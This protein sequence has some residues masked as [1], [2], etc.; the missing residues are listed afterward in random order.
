MIGTSDPV[1]ATTVRYEPDGNPPG[2][3]A[4][5]CGLQLVIVGVT[6]LVLIPALVFRAAGATETYLS[7]AVFCTVVISGASTA[8]Q[9]I[10]IGRLGAGY[11]LC[12]GPA[13]AVIGISVTA[14]VEGGPA[15]LAGLVVVS[16]LLPILVAARLSLFRRLVT[17][18]LVGTVKMLIAA[19]VLPVV[20]GRLNE[21]PDGT[22]GPGAPL[23]AAATMLVISVISLKGAA[24]LRPWA[25][26]MGVVAGSAVAA[27]FG[28]YDPDRVAAAP[29][30]GL[31]PVAWPGIESELG[32]AFVGLLPAFLFVALIGAVQTVTAAVG[33]QRVSWRR[34]RAVDSRSVQGA[35]AADG[36][37]GLLA[38][39]AGT[40]PTQTSAVSIPAAALTGVG[41]RR[42]GIAAGAVMLG[43]AFL[44]K[45][46]ALLLAIP[47]PVAVAFI[48]VLLAL[49]LVRGMSQ[50]VHGGID[51][52]NVLIAGVA[53][54]VGV[55]C[56]AGVI[57]PEQLPTL[58]G[59]LLQNGITVG[60]LV[61]I[62]MTLV[63]EATA[64]RP[65]RLAVELDAAGLSKLRA[66]VAEFASRG[67]WDEKMA[68]RLEAASDESLRALLD[69]DDGRAEREGRRV[70]LS[71]RKDVRGAILEFVAAPGEDNMGDWIGLAAE[72]PDDVLVQQKVSLRLLRRSASSVLH[73]QFHETDIVTVRVD[74][75]GTIAG[76]L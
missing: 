37:A 14:L 28:H 3:L 20:F 35:V 44:P 6:G 72:R 5:G 65:G 32:P 50:V 67:G 42:V 29:W 73:Q 45:A 40:M 60:G 76:G 62:L 68:R 66:F 53:F 46:L 30:V 70:L 34:P 63:L 10:R 36:V 58:A 33:I 41:A 25:P 8:L 19:T 49:S 13:V 39:I 15:L 11:V 27:W 7:W 12:A 57:F 74:A 64:P 56:H 69:R 24:R 2:R 51:H 18:T 1:R 26:V 71:A 17:P 59:G 55:G 54:G 48:T 75:P 22:A 9:A 21:V 47:A 43:L 4:F 23:T 16:S 52:R 61:A 38:G 31:P